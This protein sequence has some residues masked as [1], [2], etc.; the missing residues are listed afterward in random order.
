[1]TLLGQML[2]G[3]ALQ[4][5]GLKDLRWFFHK[6][7]YFEL[8]MEDKICMNHFSLELNT[9]K[10][11]INDMLLSKSQRQQEK[12]NAYVPTDVQYLVEYRSKYTYN[13]LYCTIV[14]Y[15]VDVYV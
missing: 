2:E 4:L 8:K 1:M 14:Q 13:M 7:K 10:Q 5:E 15:T 6:Q 9:W 12:S 11:V 3:K